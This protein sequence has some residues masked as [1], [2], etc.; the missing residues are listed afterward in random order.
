MVKFDVYASRTGGNIKIGLHNSDDTTTE[1][2]PYIASANAFQTITWDFS[3][4]PNSA[5]NAIDEII[6][7]I[8]NADED[9]VFY[10]D[11]FYAI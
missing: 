11:N 9:N 7:T 5:K 6:V 1:I 10:L 3:G 8:V 4:V 2:T